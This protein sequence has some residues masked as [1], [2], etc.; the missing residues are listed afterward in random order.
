MVLEVD[1]PRHRAPH[2]QQHQQRHLSGADIFRVTQIFFGCLLF[3]KYFF[4]GTMNSGRE[5]T[6]EVSAEEVGSS[7]VLQHLHYNTSA[8]A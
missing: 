5:V 3:Q 1:R 4:T 2:H 8:L 6:G 7:V